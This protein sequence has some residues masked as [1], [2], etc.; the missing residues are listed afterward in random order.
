[1]NRLGQADSPYLLQHADNP[2][3]WYPWGEAALSRAREEDKPIF[4]SIGYSTCH[5]CHVMERESFENEEVAAALN[6]HFISIKVDRESRPDIDEIYMLATQ[7]MT[8]RG[9]WPNS[10]FLTPSGEPFLAGTYFP[11]PRFLALLEAVVKEWSGNRKAILVNAGRVADYIRD[12]Q[13]RRLQ[14]SQMTPAVFAAAAGSLLSGFDDLQGG[15]SQAPKFPHESILAFLLHRAGRDD[16]RAALDAALFTLNAMQIGGIHDQAGGGFHRYSTDNAWLVPHFEKMLY[17][18]AQLAPLYARAHGLSGAPDLAR[19]ARRIADYVLGDLTSPEG[20]FYAARDADS[21]GKEGL[22]YIWTRDEISA[23]LPPDDAALIIDI[24]NISKGGNFEGGNIPHLERNLTDLAIERGQQPEEFT[25]RVDALLERMRA[26]RAK[27]PEPHRDEKILTAWNGMMIAALAECG[28]L[29][30]EPRYVEAAARAA[31]LLWSRARRADGRLWR[32]IF[33]GRSGTGA[34]QEDYAW[35]ALGMI[36][37]YDVTGNSLWL[38]RAA[39]LAEKMI[40]LFADETAGDFYLTEAG[41]ELFSRPKMK[42]DGATASGNAAALEMLALLSRRRPD[43]DHSRRAEAAIA[44][45][46]GFA[47]AAPAAHAYGLMAADAFLG[48]P[49]GARAFLG[50]GALKA[51]ARWHG[52]EVRVVLKLAPGWHVNANQP[53]DK[54]LIGT[55]LEVK[56]AGG[57]DWSAPQYPD[58]VLRR[59]NFADKEMALYEGEAVITLTAGQPRENKEMGRVVLSLEVQICSDEICLEPQRA[60]LHLPYGA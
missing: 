3:D 6:K 53:L 26:A 54:E 50:Q 40:A 47:A 32:V 43:P 25:R 11:R 34:Q 52:Q 20:G 28:D 42:Y 8:G 46:S 1:M 60:L 33:A 44:A 56:A 15:F 23:L 4:L 35:L 49:Y 12:H 27:R 51:E 14:A 18:Q 37:L 58:P 2:V 9:G 59:L 24:F 19:T 31:E 21:E 55:R 17:N 38:E 39:Q 48:G 5:W 45:L 29:L 10:V 13:S 16:D 41:G 57:H 22:F 36:R 30:D 7:A